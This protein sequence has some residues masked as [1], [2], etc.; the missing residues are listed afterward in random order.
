MPKINGLRTR[1]YMQNH[2]LIYYINKD[3][4]VLLDEIKDRDYYPGVY[5]EKES[6]VEVLGYAE[7]NVPEDYMERLKM[8]VVKYS[9]VPEE[10][11]PGLEAYLKDGRF[12][13][14]IHFK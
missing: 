6:L 5:E 13:C 14:P 2:K 8:R 12:E 7:G 4:W 11:R 1:V 9:P 10:D 3:K